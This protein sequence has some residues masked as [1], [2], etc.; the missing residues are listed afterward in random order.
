MLEAIPEDDLPDWTIP[1]REAKLNRLAYNALLQAEGFSPVSSG[2]LSPL[3]DD[4]EDLSSSRHCLTS[5]V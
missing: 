3:S 4:E 2:S 5:H 1:R